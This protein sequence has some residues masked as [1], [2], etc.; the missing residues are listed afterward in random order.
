[1]TGTERILEILRRSIEHG[2]AVELDG[3]G[4]F[5][6]S[7]KAG[8]RFDGQSQPQVFLAYVAEDL[9]VV[10]RFSK[11]LR[12]AG[13]R[14]WLDKEKLLPGQNWPRAIERAIS[15]AD[16]F[17]PCFSARA[18]SKRGQ[19]QSELRYA[20]DCARRLP[21]EDVFVVPVRLEKCEVPARIAEQVHYVDLF[22]DWDRG[23]KRVIRSVRCAARKKEPLEL[24]SSSDQALVQPLLPLRNRV[25]PI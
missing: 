15:N 4:T 8:C 20:L 14:P 16:A 19:F 24:R 25:P 1:M 6:P 9:G 5:Y 10:Q 7:G 13:V 3:L 17:V 2:L 21:M 12:Q 11:D 18:A 23:V 22:P